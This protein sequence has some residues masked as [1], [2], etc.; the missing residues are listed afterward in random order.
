MTSMKPT[1]KQFDIAVLEC[2]LG[3]VSFKVRYGQLSDEA[4]AV[5]EKNAETITEFI[6]SSWKRPKKRAGRREK[7]TGVKYT[8]SP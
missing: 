2:M 7:S 4:K 3:G 5:W 1:K 8:T 6:D